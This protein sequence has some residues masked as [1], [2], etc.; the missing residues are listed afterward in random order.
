[1]ESNS[2][3]F[4]GRPMKVSILV[5]SI[6]LGGCSF[7][8]GHICGPQTPAAYCDAVAY[9]ELTHPKPYGAHWVKDGMTEAQRLD[10]IEQ[11]GGGK[12]LYVG[13]PDA[14]I[15]AERQWDETTDF[16]ARDRLSKKW[17][18]CMEANGYRYQ[19]Q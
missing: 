19:S 16:P 17:S 5:I 8:N 18:T 14:Q 6:L 12:G 15:K 7:G 11:C 4:K 2:N 10:D 3:T 13:F 9:E 1:M